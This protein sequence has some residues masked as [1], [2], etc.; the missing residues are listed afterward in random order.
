MDLDV[1]E[2]VEEEYACCSRS[3]EGWWWG[4]VFLKRNEKDG[5]FVF[6]CLWVRV[7]WFLLGWT[8][9]GSVGCCPVRLCAGRRWF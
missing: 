8:S 7:L 5:S 2:V 4:S 1:F 9:V 3:V 6:L